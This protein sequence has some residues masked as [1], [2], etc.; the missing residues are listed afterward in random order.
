MLSSSCSLAVSSSCPS[1]IAEPAN[2]ALGE[3]VR[4]SSVIAVTDL[5]E[6]DSPTIATISPRSISNETPS[7]AR[8]VPSSVA[9]ETCRSLT[10]SRLIESPHWGESPPGRLLP[11]T[12]ARSASRR[13][14]QA[15]PWVEEGVDDVDH[16][17]QHD[18][19]ERG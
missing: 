1:N 12:R 16:G 7:T 19:G 13:R 4:P 2:V 15:D 5:P 14:S 18:H 10:S 8:T 6:P 3:R 9:K 17:A 11:A